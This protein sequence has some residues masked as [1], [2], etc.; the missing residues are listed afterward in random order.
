VLSYATPAYTSLDAARSVT[1]TYSRAQATAVATVQVDATDISVEAPSKMSLLLRRPDQTW[2]TFTNNS[3][4]VFFQSGTGTTRLAAQ[5]DMSGLSTGAY[6][7]TVVVRSW[8][9]D[10]SFLESTSPI[11]LLVLRENL[12]PYGYG[13]SIAGLQRVTPT[14]AGAVVTNGDGSVAF[15]AGCTTLGSTCM[16]PKGDFTTLTRRADGSGYDRTWLDGT[17]AAFDTQGRLASMRDRYGNQ[18][19]FSYNGSTFQLAS[20]TDPAGMI[21][22]LF[23]DGSGKL[24][25]VRDPGS[26]VTQVTVNGS[27]DLTEIFD[28]D[29]VL[30]LRVTYDGTHVPQSV[31]DRRQGQWDFTYD[32]AGKLSQVTLPTVTANGQA[33]RPV[34]RLRSIEGQVLAPSGTGTSANPAPRRLSDSLRAQVKEPRGD[35]TRYALDRFGQATRIEFRDPQGRWRISTWTYNED[36]EVLRA[37]SPQGH[38][39][40]NT[41]SGPDLTNIT[42]DNTGSGTEI[43]YAAYHQVDRVWVDGNLVQ[44]NFYGPLGQLDSSKAGTS[45]TSYTY[46]GRGRVLTVTDPQGHQSTTA[47]L[48]TGTQ[49]AQSVTAPNGS[50]N[51][52]TYTFQYDGMG[53]VTSVTDHTGRLATREYDL[54]NRVTTAVGMTFPP[55]VSQGRIGGSGPAGR[56]GGPDDRRAEVH[57]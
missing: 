40:T 15:F 10:G 54:L 41:W 12:S 35:S 17:T 5:V 55:R 9:A 7:Y 23:Y 22:S 57:G 53:R 42:D 48:P 8:W 37:I 47:Y 13:W 6:D 46:D 49:N 38:S 21:T 26:R 18:T 56:P 14:S 44:Q 4:E 33:V 24:D 25:Y 1:L 27:G 2:V 51:T 45:K 32:V 29:N 50:G 28:P 31:L 36:G 30:A 39:T 3:T 20:I 19:N 34:R 11:E 52:G 16:S 43:L